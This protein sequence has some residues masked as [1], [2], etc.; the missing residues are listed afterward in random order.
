[1]LQISFLQFINNLN[2]LKQKK[3][4]PKHK[5]VEAIVKI[6]SIPKIGTRI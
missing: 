5:I 4:E 1:M 6:I 2:F 3:K